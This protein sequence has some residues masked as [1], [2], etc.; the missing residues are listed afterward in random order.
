MRFDIISLFPQMFTN[1]TQYGVTG[2]AW[3]HRLWSLYCWNPRDFVYDAHRT[4]DGRPYGGGPGMVML[5]EP[6]EKALQHALAHRGT[7]KASVVLM[8]PGGQPF[9]QAVAQ[10][11]AHGD[12]AVLVCGR[13]EGIDQRFIDAYITEE[14]SIGDFVLSGGEI[15]AQAM[16]DSV[17]RLLPGALN[18]EQSALEDS[19]HE[20]L[21]GLLDSPH[22]TRPEHYQGLKVPQV[23]LSGDHQAIALWRRQQSLCLTFE[24]RPDLINAARANHLLDKKDKLFLNLI[25]EE[26]ANK[27]KKRIQD[28]PIL[29]KS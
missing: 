5:V 9:N 23:L 18:H 7:N 20:G 27:I 13:Y 22:Y 8:S 6:L 2:R 17:I 1:L 24:K 28:N 19:F 12:G 21:S 3:Q 25:Q 10:Q 16:I 26:G 15:A 4:V 14:Y 29:L 11:W